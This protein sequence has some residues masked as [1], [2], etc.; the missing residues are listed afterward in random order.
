MDTKNEAKL[1]R[2]LSLMDE[3]S[4]TKEDFLDSFKQVLTLV[5]NLKKTN[6]KEFKLIHQAFILLENKL[7]TDSSLTLSD[8]KMQTKEIIDKQMQKMM[9]EHEAMI[10]SMD[11]KMK[12]VKDGKDADEIRIIKDVLDQI[13][14]PEYKETVLDNPEQ[15]R[16]KLESLRG[17][18]K[19]S[20]QSVQDLAEKLE[21]LGNKVVVKGQAYGSI[22]TRYIDDETPSGA[23]NGV[24][25]EF[26]ITKLPQTGSL[27]VYVNGSR[28]R[29][30]EDYTF[31]GKTITFLIAPPS[32]SIILV[33]FRY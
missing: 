18:N 28:M 6:E 19:L 2:L 9:K 20:I 13:K 7:K 27:K 31:S 23:I 10:A 22:R 17:N 3:N 26:I 14:L 21:E 5:E 30:T 4:L 32:G 12:E 1:K 25:T 8:I 33:D 16:D 29:V 15:L 11:K 24:N